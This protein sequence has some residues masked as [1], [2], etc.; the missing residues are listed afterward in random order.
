MVHRDI[1]PENAFIDR[2]GNLKIADY[3]ISIA[4]ATTTG[5]PKRNRIGLPFY[6]APEVWG[7]RT[8]ITGV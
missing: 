7:F 8:E 2:E 1:K 6:T 3:G 5:E 4:L